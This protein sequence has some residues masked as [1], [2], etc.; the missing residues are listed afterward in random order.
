M[1]HSTQTATHLPH[2][3]PY[4]QVPCIRSWV[5]ARIRTGQVRTIAEPTTRRRC[6]QQ[7]DSATAAAT[8]PVEAPQYAGEDGPF[9]TFS[10]GN[11]ALQ[12]TRRLCRFYTILCG[13]GGGRRQEP[14]LAAASGAD[15]DGGGGSSPGWGYEEANWVGERLVAAMVEEG[16][17]AD[18][19]D[20][21]PLGLTLPI[22][23][24]LHAASSQAPARWPAAAQ[25][26]VGRQDLSA[27]RGMIRASDGSLRGGGCGS[28]EDE[29]ALE[30]K[31]TLGETGY[32]NGGRISSSGAGGRN[33]AAVGVG[34]QGRDGGLGP[35]GG[36]VG[37]GGGGSSAASAVGG[38]G[39]AEAADLDGLTWVDELSSL[40][41]GRDRRV[42]EACRLL[43]GSR[44]VRFHVERSP[45]SNDHDH[46][47]RQQARLLQLAM[48]T[49]AG[50]T[51][52]G[53]LTLGTLAPLL[54][55][56]LPIPPLCLAGRIRKPADV[57]VNLD[58]A[59]AAVSPDTTAW[60]EFHNGVA[61][62]L[63]LRHEWGSGGGGAGDS[64]RS[65]GGA[66]ATGG[67]GGFEVG[68][69]SRT[70]ITYNRPAGGANNAHGGLLMA[71]GLQGHL[72]S[73]AMTD[74]FEYL[75]L[76]QESTTVGV[77]LGMAAAR[78]GSADLST[79][80]VR[81]ISVCFFCLWRCSCC[82][83]RCGCGVLRN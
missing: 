11:D 25:E 27:L 37:R 58:L 20:R 69:V 51:G 83:D 7:S 39:G 61:A 42:R 3:G 55:E 79:H 63:R 24:L 50:P 22:L 75:T 38:G 29:E 5:H 8:A 81:R 44:P 2:S 12:N 74:V 34:G 77:L 43:R 60:A 30:E 40:R 70:W 35:T 78:R 53:M 10:K 28:E 18:D 1:P 45:E 76:G 17:R 32:W 57:V 16:Y 49:L 48:R 6:Q 59:A 15:G 47:Q 33:A 80:K 52:R 72:S 31:D 26:L 4:P 41:F 64:L 56:P 46:Q 65:G 67:G 82:V 23:E 68:G 71:L 14:E 66:A 9:P 19:L 54:A 36:G 62:G 73:L 21:A 13:G